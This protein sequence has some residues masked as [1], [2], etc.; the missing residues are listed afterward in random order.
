MKTKTKTF[1]LAVAVALGVSH[2]AA[3]P[4]SPD[5]AIYKKIDAQIKQ[6]TL[7]EKVGMLHA[8]SSFTSGGVPRL[9]IPENVTLTA[10]SP[11]LEA[12]AVALS[13]RI[14]ERSGTAGCVDI[15]RLNIF[16]PK[17]NRIIP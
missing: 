2:A 9:G 11:G 7:E 3:Q 13:H 14:T 10:A 15:Y 5:V 16:I 1:H 17:N 8:N 4:A 12:A 6:M